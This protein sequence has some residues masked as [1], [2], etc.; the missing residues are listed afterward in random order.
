MSNPQSFNKIINKFQKWTEVC[1]KEFP[2]L[3]DAIIKINDS[4]NRKKKYEV[5]NTIV[6]NR[7]LLKIEKP[8]YILVADNPG[9]DEQR[10][11]RQVYLTGQAGKCARN[12]FIKNGLVNDFEKEVIVLNKS[13]VHTHSSADLKKLDGFRD[14]VENSQYFMADMAVDMHKTF[15]CKLWVVGCSELKKKGV[16]EPFLNRIKKR[17][18]SD[19]AYLKGSL[20]FYPHFSYGNFQKSVNS[21]K[22]E[23]PGIT[24]EEALEKAGK[25]SV[26]I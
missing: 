7:D 4:A 16:F 6:F 17:Y 23:V 18:L 25:A 12:F 3:K 19:A 8:K 26:K 13:C 20:F 2:D 15:G 1:K 24:I 22:R 14:L 11:D 21:V 9:K 10:E 5:E